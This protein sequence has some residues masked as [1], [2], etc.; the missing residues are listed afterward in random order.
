VATRV[1]VSTGDRFFPPDF[2][3][4]VARERL[5]IEPETMPGRHL[6]ALSRPGDLANVLVE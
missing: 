3:I 4:R 2:Q 5:G 1:I 6:V